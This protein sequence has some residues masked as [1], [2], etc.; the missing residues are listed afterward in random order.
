MLRLATSAQHGEHGQDH[1]AHG[2]DD[3]ESVIGHRVPQT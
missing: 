2:D 3:E 1:Q